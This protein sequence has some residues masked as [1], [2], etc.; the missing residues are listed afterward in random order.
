M[1]S[2]Q[3]NCFIIAETGLNTQGDTAICYAMVKAIAEAGCDSVKFQTFNAQEFTSDHDEYEMFNDRCLSWDD[4][5]GLFDYARSL[6]LVPLSTP[7]DKDAVDLICKLDAPAIKIGSDDLVHE[8]LL[9]YVGKKERPVIL[10]TGMA[11]L[12]DVSRA[13]Y[14][15]ER[16]GCPEVALLHCVSR[17]PTP[18][19]G[20]HLRRIGMLQSEF[21]PRTVGFSDHSLGNTA[22]LGAVALGAKIIEKHFTLDKSLEGPDHKFSADPEELTILVHDIRAMEGALGNRMPMQSNEELQMGLIA[23]RSIRASK[24]LLAGDLVSEDDLVYQRPGTGLMPYEADKLIGKIL[25]HDVPSGTLMSLAMVE[26]EDEIR[27]AADRK[28]A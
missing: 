22:A 20:V 14:T 28:R 9:K 24:N 16:N 4:F 19:E 15:L 18:A 27:V 5:P 23:H 11:G 6:G 13:V 12:E 25:L 3:N 26:G 8:P 21:W 1:L 10:S 7:T 2:D 17:Y